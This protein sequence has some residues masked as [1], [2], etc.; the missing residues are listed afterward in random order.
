MVDRVDFQNLAAELINDTFGDFRDDIVFSAL[1]EYNYSTQTTP[2][3][4]TASKGIRV[5]YTKNEV[6]GQ[7]IQASDYKVLV[8]QQGLGVDVRSDNVT[9]TFNSVAV[10]IVTVDQDAAQ[11]VYTLQVREL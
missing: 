7:R 4:D 10:S 2:S 6:D 8:L 5:E 3:V 1:G 9:M 11:A